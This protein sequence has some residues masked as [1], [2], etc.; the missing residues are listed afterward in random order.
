MGGLVL[1]DTKLAVILQ[2]EKEL[3]PEGEGRLEPWKVLA[4]PCF[5]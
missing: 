1:D 4:K 2:E 3:R 5:G